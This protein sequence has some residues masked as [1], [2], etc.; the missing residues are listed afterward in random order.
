MR[1]RERGDDGDGGAA[2]IQGGG[3]S[4]GDGRH[5]CGMEGGEVVAM[6]GRLVEQSES[7]C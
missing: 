4:G 3:G 5:R 6:E 1:E 2:P 7:K